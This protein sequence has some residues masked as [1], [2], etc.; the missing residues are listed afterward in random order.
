MVYSTKD[1][2]SIALATAID[3]GPRAISV[4]GQLTAAYCLSKNEVKKL[5]VDHKYNPR[6]SAWVNSVMDWNEFYDVVVPK[7]FE[8]VPNC[9]ILFTHIGEKNGQALHMFAEDRDC[10]YYPKPV[11]STA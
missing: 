1:M 7:D 5:F 8:N 9:W 6:R 3:N 2:Y 11:G 4:N 10:T